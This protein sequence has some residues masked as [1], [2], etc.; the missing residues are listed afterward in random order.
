[1]VHLSTHVFQAHRLLYHPQGPVTRVTKK[2]KKY[3]SFCLCWT[4]TPLPLPLSLSSPA[5]LPDAVGVNQFG[6]DLRVCILFHSTV[7]PGLICLHEELSPPARPAG[8]R[9]PLAS[10]IRSANP[11]P[12][13]QIS[14][15]SMQ[16]NKFVFK[17]IS[18][19]MQTNT[20]LSMQ[21][22][23][24]RPNWRLIAWFTCVRV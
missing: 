5:P 8:C 3:P 10:H 20:P 24:S 17:Q 14:P 13:K 22:N 4:C 16:T 19:S 15:L 11:S 23:K 21:T 6:L 9:P 2:K 12:C 7:W 18:F 1:M